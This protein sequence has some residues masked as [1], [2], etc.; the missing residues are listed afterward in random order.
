MPGQPGLPEGEKEKEGEGKEGEM[1]S[2]DEVLRK[3]GVLEDN[4]TP[5]V[6]MYTNFL[7]HTKMESARSYA[8]I[9]DELKAVDQQ[10]KESA[11]EMAKKGEEE[12]E[13]LE[14]EGEKEREDEKERAE[15]GEKAAEQRA[16]NC[17]RILAEYLYEMGQKVSEKFFAT[18]I[19]VVKLYRDYM[20][21]HGW[22]LIGRYKTVSSEESSKTFANFCDAEHMP[23]ASNDFLKNF[24]PRE[25]PNFDQMICVDITFHFCRWLSSKNY[26]HTNISLL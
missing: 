12:K 3:Y 9:F 11:I 19:M 24:L 15:E 4:T 13:R 25:L 1:V 20:N 2:I 26:T 16:K 23:E 6:V 18:L 7:S 10:G 8:D 22:E 17:N 5:A 14:G 21:L